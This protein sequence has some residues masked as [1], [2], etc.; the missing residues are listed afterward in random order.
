MQVTDTAAIER[1]VGEIIAGH[2]QEVAAYRS[3]K[4]K[5]LG[6]F[7]GQVMRATRGKANPQ[8]VGEVLKTRLGR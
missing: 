4:D 6:F 7:V 2:P 5:L 1:V 8:I 3:G